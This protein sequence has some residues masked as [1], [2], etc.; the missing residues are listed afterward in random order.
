[1][2]PHIEQDEARAALVDRGERRG[3]V[4]RR[5]AAIAFVAEYAGN[6]VADIAFV[7]NNEDI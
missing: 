4:S 3:A 1:M 2:E 6:E 7:V 5:A